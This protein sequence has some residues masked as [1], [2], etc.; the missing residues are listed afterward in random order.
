MKSGGLFSE[1]DATPHNISINQT[2]LID[3][4]VLEGQKDHG[5]SMHSHMIK[6]DIL[7]EKRI[8]EGTA[9]ELRRSSLSVQSN[10]QQNEFNEDAENI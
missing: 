4:T 10:R 3:L 6:K 7:S 2:N 1:R 5:R 8:A 9:V